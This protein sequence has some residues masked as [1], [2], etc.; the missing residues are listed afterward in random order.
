MNKLFFFLGLLFIT[1]ISF[2]QE[3]NC[4]VVVNAEQTGRTNVT[5]FKTLQNSLTE[6]INQ[7]KWTNR[8]FL[9]HERINCSMFINISSY[10]ADS[11]TGTIQVQSSR[12][13]FGSTMISPVF[14]FKDEQFGFTYSEYAPFSFNASEFN[15]NLT[16]VVTFYVYTILGL[17]ADTFQEQ[18]GTPYF[19]TANQI[20]NTA[21][22][23]G[24]A[25][26]KAMDG[27][28]SRYRLITDLLSNSYT[29]YRSAMYGYHR[30]GLD[31]MHMSPAEG[32][33]AIAKAILDLDRMNDRRPNS[34]VVRTFFD[35]KA[36]EVSQVFS[37]GPSV[38]VKEVVDA[39]NTLAP[40]FSE[41]WS[42]IRY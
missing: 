19:E 6:F 36:D 25:G 10:E 34:L 11:F 24:R 28:S 30:N 3:L 39:L 26:W 29:G 40:T 1:S 33:K 4:Q 23:S 8:Q 18:G 5:V 15:S 42:N 9:P 22:Q 12:P 16:S 38:S 41:K 14:N 2:G 27:N 35:A 17:D 32:K 21:Q 20:V 31:R 7:T 13:V 37:G